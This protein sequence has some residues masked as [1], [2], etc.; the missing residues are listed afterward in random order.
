MRGYNIRK[1]VDMQIMIM[2]QCKV[3]L[4]VQGGERIEM[5]P[6]RGRGECH[7]LPAATFLSAVTVHRE[8]V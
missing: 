4:E 7:E 6:S 1:G 5:V 8:S 2:V 3:F